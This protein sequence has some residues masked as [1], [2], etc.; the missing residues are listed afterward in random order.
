MRTRGHASP[1]PH[2]HQTW[3]VPAN[4]GKY[5]SNGQAG[6]VGSITALVAAPDL[7][8]CWAGTDDGN[9][10]VTRDGGATWTNVTP[11]AIKPWTR[12]FNIDAGH[13]DPPPPMPPRTRCASTRSPAFLSHARRRQDVD[14]DQHR[15]HT[16]ARSPIPSARIRGSRACSTPAPRRATCSCAAARSAGARGGA[17]RR[18][19]ATRWRSPRG[20]RSCRDQGLDDAEAAELMGRLGQSPMTLPRISRMISSVPPPIGP[21]RESRAARSMSYSTM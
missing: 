4:T 12:I 17:R 10:Q 18:P 21:R 11:P 19:S 15:Y 5:A 1:R 7:A 9:I 16:A 14:G 6:P 2:A 3:A 20:A 13:F 8:T